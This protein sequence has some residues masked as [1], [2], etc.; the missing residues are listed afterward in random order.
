[1]PS[2]F[3]IDLISTLCGYISMATFYLISQWLAQYGQ[4]SSQNVVYPI[5]QT[6]AMSTWRIATPRFITAP[7]VRKTICSPHID[8]LYLGLF[9]CASDGLPASLVT[10]IVS[11]LSHSSLIPRRWRSTIGNSTLMASCFLQEK[12]LTGI[13]GRDV[14]HSIDHSAD[15]RNEHCTIL[16]V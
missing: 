16:A 11:D 6:A 1:M 8:V 7:L 2:L 13:G 12:V 4:S 3:F 10:Y 15:F 14:H 9:Y 5:H